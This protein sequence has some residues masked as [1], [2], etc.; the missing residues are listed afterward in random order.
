MEEEE[1]RN[2]EE[3]IRI[4][5]QVKKEEM[6]RAQ[7]EMKKKEDE[8]RRKVTTEFHRSL[9]QLAYCTICQSSDP[10]YIVGYYVYEMGHYFLDI[11]CSI[12]KNGQ[13]LVNISHKNRNI[14]LKSCSCFYK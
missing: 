8:I 12:C 4:E 14:S 13:D 1:K 5:L 10:F 6:I 11:L 2:E 9:V 7:M 3:R